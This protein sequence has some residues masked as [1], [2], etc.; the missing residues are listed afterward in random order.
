[1]RNT[2]CLFDENKMTADGCVSV[3]QLQTFLSCKRKWQYN[4]IE[5]LKPRVERSYL[6]VGKLCHK[7]MQ[8]AM[9]AAWNDQQ[10][11]LCSDYKTLDR[12]KSWGEA[13]IYAMEEE[14]A[15]YVNTTPL[16]K[17]ELPDLD[18]MVK[19]AISIFVQAFKEFE[20]WKYEVLTLYKGGKPIPA[21]ELHFKVPCSPTRGM[22]GYIDAILKD[23][24]TGFIWCTDYK[25]RKSLS[26][27]EDESFNIQNAVY[28]YA[29][30]KMGIDVTGTM[31]W[32]HLNT[33]AATPAILKDGR[34]SR[35]KIK[36]TWEKYEQFCI[37]H[38]QDPQDYYPEMEEKLKDIEWYRAT[39]EYRNDDTIDRIW[40]ECVLPVARRIKSARNVRANNFRSLY[41]WN[42]KMCQYKTLCQAEL[43][44][45]DS[46]YIRQSEYCKRSTE[47][48]D[49]K[50]I[51]RAVDNVL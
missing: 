15:E 31:T 18:K 23:T 48:E 40:K 9:Q 5:N 26:P 8:V 44:D 17:E 7:G 30:K 19:D 37:E 4:Y 32:Q 35:T 25:F 6:T 20:P 11:H 12:W 36:T 27:D 16:L 50:P 13:G 2:R 39:L 49:N 3:S 51:D 29:C 1:M 34:I 42:C 41:P 38:G 21:L 22:H 46:E 28:I 14:F 45:Y 47:K 33:P 24:N 10:S 43:R